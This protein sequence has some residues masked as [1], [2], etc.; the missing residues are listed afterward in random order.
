MK[1]LPTES[2]RIIG[3]LGLDKTDKNPK[4]KIDYV[5][6]KCLKCN[7]TVFVDLKDFEN[8]KCECEK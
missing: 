3:I 8:Y 7:K 5:L 1:K 2:E 4:K 6:V